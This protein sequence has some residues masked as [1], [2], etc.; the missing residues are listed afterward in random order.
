MTFNERLDLIL[1]GRKITPWGK[2]LGLS[3]SV[4]QTLSGGN[5]PGSDYL[6]LISRAENIN[7]NFLLN[8]QGAPFVVQ[9]TDPDYVLSWLG[10]RTPATPGF[11]HLILC[12]GQTMFGLETYEHIDL[13]GRSVECKRFDLLASPINTA[14]LEALKTFDD[15]RLTDLPNSLFNQLK[16]GR[17]GAFLCLGDR[18]AKG[19]LMQRGGPDLNQLNLSDLNACTPT[20]GALDLRLLRAVLDIV[21]DVINDTGEVLNTGEQSKVIASLYKSATRQGLTASQLQRGAVQGL[22]DML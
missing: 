3:N 11:M 7:I 20:N 17:L 14:L 10:D 4:I 22:L 15:I 21:T 13:R 1:Q 16:N 5:A 8:G 18:N 12:D 2:A 9:H 6:Q 19:V